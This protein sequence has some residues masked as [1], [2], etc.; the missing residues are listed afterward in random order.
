MFGLGMT[1]GL[2]S[3]CKALDRAC[4]DSWMVVG[5]EVRIEI[6]VGG[7]PVHSCFQVL[8]SYNIVMNL[9]SIKSKGDGYNTV[10]KLYSSESVFHS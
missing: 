4:F 8:P 5:F 10:V 7:L 3:V 9:Y 6:R 1:Y 2:C